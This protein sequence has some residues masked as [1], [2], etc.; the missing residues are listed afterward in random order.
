MARVVLRGISLAGLGYV[1]TQA[2]TFVSYLA[3]ARLIEPRDF[4]HFAAGILVAGIGTF[5]GDGGMAAAVI[6]RQDGGEE[7]ANTAFVSTLISG[8]LMTL[9]ALATA[10]LMGLFFH[11]HQV[12]LIAFAMSGWLLLRMIE[13][14][15][16]A[17]LQRR[18][19]F[20]RRVIIDPLAAVGFL[21]VAIVAGSDGLG[22]WTLV[23]ATYTGAAVTAIAAW[24]LARWRPRPRLAS[25][26]TWRELA[27]YGRPVVVGEV[28]RRGVDEIPVAGVGRFIAAGALG[29]YT[30]AMRVATQPFG[31]IVNAVAYVLLPSFARLAADERRLRAAVVRALRGVCAVA[32]PAGLI[33]IPL[34]L[35]AMTTVF[36][37]RWHQAGE[38][39][40]ALAVSCAVLSLDSLASEIWKATGH[41]RYMPRMHGLA[42]V[43]TLSLVSAA[44]PFG[45]V[46]VCGAVS[47][48]AV[49]VALYALWGIHEAIGL[50]VR[51]LAA[52]ALPPAVSAAVM[53]AALYAVDRLSVHAGARPGGVALALLVLE[54][55]LGAV[56]YLLTLRLIA[57]DATAELVALVRPLVARIQPK[58]P[59]PPFTSEYGR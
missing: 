3:L 10:P 52:Q 27:T 7:V 59:R 25:V 15:P 47:L 57:P 20:L 56:L 23:L 24:A 41:V 37:S 42:F 34:G 46:A 51:T 58:L 12:E 5:V 11:S 21:T 18:L 14:V 43:L 31:L 1:F 39:L 36:G 45:L 53:A 2:I 22:A 4:G 40:M 6:R 50:P 26:R 49:G 35:P 54:A 32:F 17:L 28:I 29:Q 44:V 33:L 8:A 16:Q 30:Y 19:S 55:L 9:F 13:I 38:A 48:A